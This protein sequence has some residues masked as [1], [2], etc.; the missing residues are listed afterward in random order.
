MSYDVNILLE[1]ESVWALV[2]FW[3]LYKLF[4]RYLFRYSTVPVKEKSRF[5]RDNDRGKSRSRGNGAGNVKQS[6]S[7]YCTVRAKGSTHIFSAAVAQR[8]TF[9]TAPTTVLTTRRFPVLCTPSP[10]FLVLADISGQSSLSQEPCVV[11][12]KSCRNHQYMYEY[13]HN[14]PVTHSSYF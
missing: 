1:I 6:I 8:T 11:V 7:Q 2:N 10:W 12:K 3:T 13:L 4:S 5:P 9:S 14:V